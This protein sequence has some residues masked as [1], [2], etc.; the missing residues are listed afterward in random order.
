[1]NP[2]TLCVV[3]AVLAPPTSA[4]IAMADVPACPAWAG[5]YVATVDG[6]SVTICATPT[7]PPGVDHTTC[8]Y[9]TGMVRVD[10]STGE[11]KNFL[12]PCV[13]DPGLADAADAGTPCFLDPCVPPGTYEYGYGIPSFVFCNES[14]AGPTSGE[15][16]TVVTVSS[17]ACAAEGGPQQPIG[18]SPAIWRDV[19][20]AVVDGAVVW[21]GNCTGPLPAP[22]G[23]FCAWEWLDGSAQWA[24]CPPDGGTLCPWE[25]AD[26]ATIPLPCPTS[27]TNNGFGGGGNS[28]GPS[29]D[30]GASAPS[31][32]GPTA[33]APASAS[34][35][36]AASP[37]AAAGGNG[38]SSGC[39]MSPAETGAPL[40]A[41]AALSLAVGCGVER[42]RRRVRASGGPES[43]R[44][45][46]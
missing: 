44:S 29:I 14:C 12:G 31:Q 36:P 8:P 35:P 25:T 40:A 28:N 38:G 1:M 33:T 16:A 41:L 42:R 32:T 4:A 15:W 24:P 17:T 11:S 2:R 19:D 21:S 6:G 46:R 7:P 13:A 30:A 39:S 37:S 45:R 18:L 22:D 3:L 23:G 9:D 5:G 43:R 20:A 10:V 26:G 34:S 27:G